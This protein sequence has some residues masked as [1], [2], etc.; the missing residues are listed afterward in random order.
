MRKQLFVV[1]MAFVVGA[2]AAMAWAQPRPQPR[3]VSG[4]DIGFRLEGTDP[5][6]GQPTGTLVVR[7]DGEWVAVGPAAGVRLLGH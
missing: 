6:T 2:A 3:I 7:I 1:L 5:Q 4:D